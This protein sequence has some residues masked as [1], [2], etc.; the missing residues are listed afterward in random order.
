MK[1]KIDSSCAI[2]IEGMCCLLWLLFPFLDFSLNG[3]KQYKK[4]SPK[5]LSLFHLHCHSQVTSISYVHFRSFFLTTFNQM[6]S[7][8]RHE[9]VTCENCGTQT[10]KLNLARHKKRC[11]AGTLYCIQCS[12]FSTKS[13]N[14]L[15]YH[16]AKKHSAPKIDV[17]FKC[18][19]CHQEFPGLHA[20]RQ[21]KNT[22]HGMQIGSGTRDVDVE[23]MV[24]DVDD[25]SLRESWNLAKTF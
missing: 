1:G 19:L 8:N 15:I 12:N 16:F 4:T 18:K 21:H 17:N 11:S 20:L 10:T 22:Q 9:K 23:S 3:E 24:G 6:P 7:L 5:F 14:D 2:S 25:Q 13:Q